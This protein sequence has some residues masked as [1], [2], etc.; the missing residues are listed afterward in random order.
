MSRAGPFSLGLDIKR[1]VI[2]MTHGAG[3][4]ASA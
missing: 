2:D 3:G 4:R 1:G